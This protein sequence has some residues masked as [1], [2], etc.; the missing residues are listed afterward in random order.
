[1]HADVRI[2]TSGWHYEHWREVFYPAGLHASEWLPYYAQQF[3]AVEINNSFY[4]LPAVETLHAWRDAVP[5]HFRFAAKGSRYLTHMK[6]LT[7]PSAALSN[8]LP[9]LEALAPKLGPVL[10]QLPAHWH[11]NPDRLAAFLAALPT[12][13]RYAFEF[14]DPSWH[15]REV[16]ALLEQH[17]AAFCIFDLAGFH[18]DPIVTTDFAYV[19]LHGP[20]QAYAG[21]YSPSALRAWA[22]RIRDWSGTLAA[23]HLYFDNDQAGYAPRNA[24]AL[25]ALL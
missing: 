16:Y 24:R 22:R 11:C 9:R 17:R 7:D 5:P 19:R 10:F 13:H 6:K 20:A 25:R 2:G 12:H 21:S 1:V 4:Q 8:L 18:S 14:R 15:V 3:D 23:V